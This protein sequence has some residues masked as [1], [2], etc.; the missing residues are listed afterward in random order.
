M[1][2]DT[3]LAALVHDYIYKVQTMTRQEADE[4]FNEIMI[5]CEVFWIKRTLYYLWVRLG[6]W[7]AWKKHKKSLQK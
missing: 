5:I 3:L 1:A 7:V 6:G 4:L 2:T